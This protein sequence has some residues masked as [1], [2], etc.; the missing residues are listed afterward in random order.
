[1]REGLYEAMRDEVYRIMRE[2]KVPYTRAVELFWEQ[3]ETPE[4]RKAREILSGPLSD[5]TLQKYG[6]GALCEPDDPDEEDD[7]F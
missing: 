2:E 6:W 3:W 5:E 4:E 1:M 7:D